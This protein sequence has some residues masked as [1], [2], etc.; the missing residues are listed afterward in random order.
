M[1]RRFESCRGRQQTYRSGQRSNSP[2]PQ[3]H[4]DQS[5]VGPANEAHRNT[6]GQRRSE[7]TDRGTCRPSAENHVDDDAT[8]MRKI[9]N[10]SALWVFGTPSA[11]NL[12]SNAQSSKGI[13]LQSSSAHF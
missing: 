7:F 2:E 3:R 4:V 11:A 8:V 10:R 9:P 5:L 13:T 12:R 1:R 6:D